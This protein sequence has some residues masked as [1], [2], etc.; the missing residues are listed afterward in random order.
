MRADRI[1]P[2]LLS[3]DPALL[4]VTFYDDAA[5][6][7]RGERI[8]LSGKVLANW[9]NKAANLLQD[10]F[11]LSGEHR[12]A[13]APARPLADGLLGPGGL[14][15]RRH[16]G[17]RSGGGRSGPAD[18]RRAAGGHPRHARRAGP[19][20]PGEPR[21]RRGRGPRTGHVRRPLRGVAQ[22]LDDRAALSTDSTS[23]RTPTWCRP[24]RST[25]RWSPATWPRRCAPWRDC[26][27]RTA[28]W[29]WCATPTR[30]R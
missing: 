28:R 13:R 23:G 30:P 17:H 19:R 14:V 2:T 12:C 5:G 10:E 6:P 21:R 7:T 26:W 8:E 29:C 15:G 18:R 9:V 1:V 4:R 11:D 22:P 25:A 3:S 24:A 20:T 27:G 16:R